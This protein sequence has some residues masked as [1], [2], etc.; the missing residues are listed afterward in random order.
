MPEPKYEMARYLHFLEDQCPL[1]EPLTVT[2]FLHTVVEVVALF[3]DPS[4]CVLCGDED[5]CYIVTTELWEKHGPMHHYHICIGCFEDR[6][7][8]K[9]TPEDFPDCGINRGLL[10]PLS[11]RH[12]DRMA[13]A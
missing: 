11:E 6:L 7:G 13:K 1:D 10:V 2:E 4:E 5:D 8:R 9:L 3:P 12:K